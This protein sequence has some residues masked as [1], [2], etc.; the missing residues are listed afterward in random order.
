MCEI[1]WW[2]HNSARDLRPWTTLLPGLCALTF[3]DPVILQDQDGRRRNRSISCL[4]GGKS[5]PLLSGSSHSCSCPSFWSS[6]PMSSSV[7]AGTTLVTAA[8]AAGP[9]LLSPSLRR[10]STLAAGLTRTVP[11]DSGISI[12]SEPRLSTA[13]DGWF[14]TGGLFPKGNGS[15]LVGAGVARVVPD[16][17]P[18]VALCAT[19]ISSRDHSDSYTHDDTPRCSNRLSNR[20]RRCN[21][22]R[23]HLSHQAAIPRPCRH[24]FAHI[25]RNQCQTAEAGGVRR[26][27]SPLSRG[28]MPEKPLRLKR[29]PRLRSRR[30]LKPNLTV[31]LLGQSQS[32]IDN[33]TA[34]STSRIAGVRRCWLRH[35]LLCLAARPLS[36]HCI[37]FPFSVRLPAVC[38]CCNALTANCTSSNPS[39][40]TSRRLNHL[41]F[42]PSAGRGC[43]D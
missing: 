25:P 9:S 16:G 2:R 23:S 31:D 13:L 21:C 34:A 32:Y 30:A 8:V 38:S 19:K 15:S 6:T 39:Y 4:L 43:V 10:R 33:V 5:P 3:K 35:S 22:Q 14:A 36:L 37:I 12:S 26:T 29:R 41:Q 24:F 28:K 27:P 40:R 20:S 1:P 11:G 7:C 18:G 17:N 42:R